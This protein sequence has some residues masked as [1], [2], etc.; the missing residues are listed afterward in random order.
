ML[1][2]DPKWTHAG[3]AN[4]L[5]DAPAEM[6]MSRAPEHTRL[7]AA[8]REELK[9]PPPHQRIFVNRNLRMDTVRAVG[10]DMDYTLARY[11]GDKLEELAHRLTVEKLIARGY[12]EA[13]ADFHYDR[14][15]VIRGLTVDK[16]TGNILKLDRH[17]HVGRVFHGRRRL[18]KR[19]RRASYRREKIDFIPPRFALVDTLFS[20]PE[21]CLYADLIDFLAKHGPHPVDTWKLFDDTRECIDEAHRDD[22]LKSVVT[23]DLPT[24]IEHDPMLART[25]HK[26][27]SAGKKIFLLT[28]SYWEYTDTLM[29]YLLGDQ[30]SEYPSWRSYFEVV[31][32]GARKPGFFTGEEPVAQL[33]PDSATIVRRGVRRFERGGVY[34]GGNLAAFERCL[35]YSGEDILYV[36]DHIYGDILSS[37]KSSLWRT[38]LI[39]EELEDEMKLSANHHA[40]VERLAELEYQRRDLDDLANLQR[41]SLAALEKGTSRSAAEYLELKRARDVTKRKL[42]EVVKG[43]ARIESVLDQSFNRNWGMVFKEGHENSRF[44]EQVAEY[45]CLY[46]S[47]VTNFAHYSAHQYFRSRRDLMAHERL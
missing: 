31:C 45:A 11:H 42:R 15:F 47:R 17:S 1:V 32:V 4:R 27:R 24:Y 46:T 6:T 43:M 20:L 13:I 19:E 36:G 40:D 33:D 34:E 41:R 39:V 25:L 5:Y 30:L 44:G 10:F 28:N 14:S 3:W 9:P 38:A 18:S 7:L 12:P 23:A 37:K 16:E 8:Q 22:T 35:G 21:M 26:L 2:R 29:H